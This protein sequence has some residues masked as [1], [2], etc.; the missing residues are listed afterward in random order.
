VSV[1]S[2]L[3]GR[4]I[5]PAS[6]LDT[7]T[8]VYIAEDKIVAIGTPPA[9]FHADVERQL[10]ARGLIVCPG[11]VDLSVRLRE[12]GA[13]HK[14]TI[15]SETRAAANNGI[16]SICCPP[17]TDPVIDTPAVA[18]LLQQRALYSG[19]SKVYP[20]AAL[21]KNLQGI[22]LAEM[23]DLKEAGCIGVSNSLQPIE[24]TEVLRHAMEYAANCDLTLFI[25]PKDPWLGRDG[26]MH[27]SAV[28]T[29]LGLS[30]IPAATETI[31]IANHLL[32]IE[33]TGVR[34]HFCRLSTARAV[35]MLAVARS[36]GLPVTADVCAHQLFLTDQDIVDYNA[37]YRVYPPLR[38]EQDREKL[39]AGVVSQ[40]VT[41]ICSDHQPH[42]VDAKRVPFAMAAFGISALD[43]FLSL[44]L[45]F[46]EEMSLAL[47]T[48][49]SYVTH[50]PADILGI[51][52]G[53]LRVGGIADICIFDTNYQ[54][55]LQTA[56]MHSSGTNSPFLNQAFKGQ[57]MHTLIN[58][59]VVFSATDLRFKTR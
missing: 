38:G 11:L 28:S 15:L 50:R 20:L 40:A 7:I 52:A 48:A 34:A 37:Q 3:G 17:D 44:T 22:Q 53:R 27:E 35:E 32:L 16:T 21:T 58:G 29:R 55:T 18:E 56:T 1:F 31:A 14:G 54:W 5:D 23:N 33:M 43:T 24:N 25:H 59:K 30:G 12:P 49:L 51:D 47:P 10:D 19:M 2:I 45:R 13:E 46:A 9:D 41:A 4:V 57:V 36:Q 42:E 6:G 39:R 8:D 26:C